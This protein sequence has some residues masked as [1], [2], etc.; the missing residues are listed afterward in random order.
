ME[1]RNLGQSREIFWGT[2]TQWLGRSQ[3][4]CLGT[5]Q[6]TIFRQYRR[7]T[8]RYALAEEEARTLEQLGS[9]GPVDSN[10]NCIAMYC[11]YLLARVLVG[12]CPTLILGS[13]C[14]KAGSL[15]QSSSSP[16]PRT[17]ECW[18]W[19]PPRRLGPGRGLVAF[20]VYQFIVPIEGFWRKMP[21]IICFRQIQTVLF[22]KSE[23]IVRHKRFRL[24]LRFTTMTMSIF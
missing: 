10:L 8:L 24:T 12:S 15:S 16:V 4:Q 7:T 22:E 13:R 6:C 19:R 17:W 5:V 3:A 23:C 1:F 18:L 20:L 2:L 21:G 11:L 9:V 14:Q